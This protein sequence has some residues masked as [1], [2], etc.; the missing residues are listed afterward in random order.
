LTIVAVEPGMAD[1]THLVVTKG[2]F[3]NVLALCTTR[4]APGG[5]T[6][7]DEAQRARLQEGF[8]EASR[9]GM[10]VLALATRRVPA[11]STY[12]ARDECDM[13]FEGL[14]HF[15][16]PPK[17]NAALAVRE[18]AD[19]GIAI[20][21]ITGDNRHVAAHVAA[22][23]GLRRD[24]M[25]TGTE[26]ASMPDEALWHQAPR[27]DLFVEVDPQQKERIVRALQRTGHAVGYLGDGI[28]DAPALHAADVGI[29]VDDAVDVARENA[30]IVLLKPDLHVLRRGVLDGR[31]TFANTLKYIAITTSAN[32]GNMV[33]MAIGA[34][35]LPFLPL[36]AKQILL[37]NLLSDVPSIAISTDRVDAEHLATPQRWDVKEV[38]RFMFVFGL[39]STVF[40]LLTFWLLLNMFD[41]DEATFQ[42]AWFTVSLLTELAVVMSLR[43]GG[44]MWRSRPS[45]LL[46][47]STLA[48]AALAVVLPLAAPMRALFGFVTLQPSLVAALGATVLAYVA[49][50]EALKSVWLHASWQHARAD[51][52]TR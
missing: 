50:T 31:H 40:D 46:L 8:Q 16:D 9:Q 6:P 22:T 38:R 29:S 2:A 32:F 23:I 48:V 44:R 10:R 27:T 42:T 52:R 5:A 37:N 7:L 25:L 33:S 39:V 24:S 1:G 17:P 47:G 12:E 15:F 18:L 20:K 45:S 26:L 41:A 34:L 13:N 19:L 36:A 43:T 49:A 14:L 3:D 30:D 35:F 21:V 51:R 28:N 11:Q 4:A